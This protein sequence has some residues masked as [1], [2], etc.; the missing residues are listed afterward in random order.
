MPSTLPNTLP[1][2]AFVQVL[3]ESSLLR[4][5]IGRMPFAGKQPV[6]R[7][8]L[9]PALE[10][11]RSCHDGARRIRPH[12]PGSR[13]PAAQAV[14]DKA[15]NR[16]AV[17]GAG[18]AVAQPPILEGIGCRAL[19]LDQIGHDLDGG[20]DACCWDHGNLFGLF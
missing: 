9:Q 16:C 18:K 1:T 20:L 13:R 12:Q 3:D 7:G 6:D 19:A 4:S 10:F 17:L 15:G 5:S 11:Q 8:R 14:I 2:P